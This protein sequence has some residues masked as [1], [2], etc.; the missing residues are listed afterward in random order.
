MDHNFSF[1]TSKIYGVGVENGL[2][3]YCVMQ[4]A[5]VKDRYSIRYFSLN[6]HAR[7]SDPLSPY[8]FLI[9]FLYLHIILTT[10]S[11]EKTILP[12]KHSDLMYLK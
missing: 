1:E 10:Y 7:R 8:F 2:E 5:A 9:F 4:G 11:I 6:C 3:H 12:L